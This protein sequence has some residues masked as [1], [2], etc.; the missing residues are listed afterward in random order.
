[1]YGYIRASQVAQS[2]KNPPAMQETACRFNPWVRKI[3]WKGNSNSFQCS[4]LGNPMDRGA[5]WATV[6]PWG[7]K[8]SDMTEQLNHHHHHHKTSKLL[9]IIRLIIT[10]MNDK[11]GNLPVLKN[12]NVLIYVANL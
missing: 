9:H 2:G 3:P 4:C 12:I 6:S 8:E 5:W 1:M 11:L 7:H 10:K